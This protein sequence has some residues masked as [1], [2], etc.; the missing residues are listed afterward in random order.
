VDAWLESGA[1]FDNDNCPFDALTADLAI[2][3]PV[4]FKPASG[5]MLYW[6]VEDL[7]TQQLLQEGNATTG[8]DD[9]VSI[10]GIVLYP[11]ST[12]KVRITIQKEGVSTNE[13]GHVHQLSMMVQPNPSQG[14]CNIQVMGKV[15]E[16]SLIRVMDAKGQIV[17]LQDAELQE[18]KNIVEINSDDTWPAGLYV[19]LLTTPTSVAFAKWIKN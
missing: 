11:A 17:Y 10:P 16:E 9:L 2:R 3:K 14:E 13:A 8:D 18:G 12:R 15:Q 4:L 1:V 7:S 5:D 19:I 6:K